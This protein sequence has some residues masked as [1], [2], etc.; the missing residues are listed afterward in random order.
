MAVKTYRVKPGKRHGAGNRY[1]PGELVTLEEAHA[2]GFLDKLELVEE[3]VAGEQLTVGGFDVVKAT[4]AEVLAAVEA[5]TLSVADAL[6]AELAGKQRKS[7][8]EALEALLAVP[9]EK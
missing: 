5:G 2:A 7:L 4:V 1:G 6:E 8:L 9:A 3:P